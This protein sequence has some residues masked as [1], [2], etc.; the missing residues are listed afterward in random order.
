MS[1]EEVTIDIVSSLLHI[2]VYMLLHCIRVSM[3]CHDMIMIKCQVIQSSHINH[4][5][6][7]LISHHHMQ[8]VTYPLK[9]NYTYKF[10]SHDPRRLQIRKT[11][12]PRLKAVPL[13]RKGRVRR[14]FVL[15]H[16]FRHER[17][18][19]IRPHLHNFT[20]RV[21]PRHPCVCVVEEEAW[22]KDC[23]SLLYQRWGKYIFIKRERD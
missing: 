11:A 14:G 2:I 3:P 7:F 1:L 13:S 4:T 10:S 18:I 22:K 12:R 15:R 23:I 16:D 5:I 17:R 6:H 21:P 9:M 20:L 8:C 19:Q